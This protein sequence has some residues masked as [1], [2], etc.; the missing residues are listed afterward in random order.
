ML[1]RE[2]Q[3]AQTSTGGWNGAHRLLL[4]AVPSSRCQTCTGRHTPVTAGRLW[5]IFVESS[6]ALSQRQHK[7]QVQI[8]SDKEQVDGTEQ[9]VVKPDRPTPNPNP[10][11]T[12]S[13]GAADSRA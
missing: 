4:S 12:I 13:T 6:S 7:S 3:V 11:F 1:Q 9:D 8:H 5:R 2:G 10:N